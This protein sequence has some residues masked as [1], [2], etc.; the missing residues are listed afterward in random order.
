M[1]WF[2]KRRRT[3][4]R[5]KPD[6]I[7]E[8]GRAPLLRRYS[9]S[10]SSKPICASEPPPSPHDTGCAQTAVSIDPSRVAIRSGHNLSTTSPWKPRWRVRRASAYAGVPG[11]L[12]RP[13][14]REGI[15]APGPHPRGDPNFLGALVLGS[16]AGTSATG[17]RVHDM[18]GT[19]RT[20]GFDL[21]QGCRCDPR[22]GRSHGAAG[23]SV[24]RADRAGDVGIGGIGCSRGVAA[25]ICGLLAGASGGGRVLTGRAALRG[26]ALRHR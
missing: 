15:Y 13:L 4:K 12:R 11:I 2:R 3:S 8:P 25:L 18:K 1:G 10:K 14:R 9:L 20:L 26:G 21:D 22:D 6:H 24:H 19:M 7:F 5:E 16:P 23:S 17:L